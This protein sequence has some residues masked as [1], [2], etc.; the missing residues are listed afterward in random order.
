MYHPKK[1]NVMRKILFSIWMLVFVFDVMAHDKMTHLPMV[2]KGVI[3]SILAKDSVRPTV[4]YY[5]DSTEIFGE[6]WINDMLFVYEDFNY[7]SLPD[8]IKIRLIDL[9]NDE[10]F[11][12]PRNGSLNSP[13]GPRWGRIHH[14]L[15]LSL[16]T[17]DS[18][19]SAFDGIVRYAE[20]NNGGYGNCVIVRH[21]NGLETLYAHLSKIKVS[22]NQMVQAG[23]LVGLGGSTGRSDGPHLHFETRYKDFSFDPYSY[24]DKNTNTLISDSLILLKAKL[25]NYRYP[26]DA[27]NKTNVLADEKGVKDPIK[28]YSAGNKSKYPSPQKKAVKTKQVYHV[29]KKG[30]SISTIARKYKTTW[31]QIRKLNKL[32]SDLL[33]PGKK[34]RVK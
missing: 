18:V 14:G 30:E 28:K 9:E 27:K 7:T 3:D 19:F 23:D 4:E 6:F 34:L 21:F 22:A 17:G 26:T 5:L 8:T 2:S 32:K 13:Y 16:R 25:I 29:V 1:I 20:F 10:G 12:M 24:I 33:Q 15:D 11:Q 31:V